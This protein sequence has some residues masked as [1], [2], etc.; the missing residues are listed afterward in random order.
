MYDSRILEPDVLSL[1]D[2]GR[3]GP[4]PLYPTKLGMPLYN[5]SRRECMKGGMQVS[6]LAPG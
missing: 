1:L 3:P 5:S 2:F 4:H 6:I